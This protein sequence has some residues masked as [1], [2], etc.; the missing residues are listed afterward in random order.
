MRGDLEAG[1][2]AADWIANRP[3]VGLSL[4]AR[5]TAGE[6]LR[7]PCSVCEPGASH[8][9][10]RDARFS[11]GRATGGSAGDGIAGLGSLTSLV[12]CSV[13]TTPG[14]EPQGALTPS[15]TLDSSVSCNDAPDCCDISSSSR[16]SDPSKLVRL[17]TYRG[18]PSSRSLQ[19]N[20]ADCL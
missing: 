4:V 15:D 13:A 20:T 9:E 6:C 18:D 11:G 12:T 1:P 10:V 5:L 2:S 3:G 14:S 16:I 17:I 19:L 8:G 7:S